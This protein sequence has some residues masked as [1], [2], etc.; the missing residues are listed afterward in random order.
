MPFDLAAIKDFCRSEN[1]SFEQTSPAEI[2]VLIGGGLKLCFAHTEAGTDTYIGFSDGTWHTHDALILMTGPDTY[3]KLGP[4]EILEQ[5]KR[6]D[7]LIASRYLRDELKDRRLFHR[8]EKQ[9][10]QYFEA[11]ETTRIERARLVSATP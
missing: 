5:I 9:D 3:V 6:G 2:R 10:F 8:M 1:V 11:G 4:V 7:L